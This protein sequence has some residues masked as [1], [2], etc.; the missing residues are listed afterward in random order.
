MNF[1]MSF[2]VGV[3]EKN[4]NFL[5]QAKKIVETYRLCSEQLSY[6]PHYDYGLRAV[7]A[8]L[9]NINCWNILIKLKYKFKLF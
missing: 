6:Q 1:V 5:F 9:V 4:W 2:K 7:K 8:V 3:H